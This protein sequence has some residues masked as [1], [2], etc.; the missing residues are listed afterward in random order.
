M[1]AG[2][3]QPAATSGLT[4]VTAGK[5]RYAPWVCKAIADG[6]SNPQLGGALNIVVHEA[7]HLFGERDESVAACWGL[8][9]AAD[10]ARRFYNVPF[11]SVASIKVMESARAVHASLSA[12]YHRVCL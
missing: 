9:W 2:A 12:D 10:L 3:G 6:P 7:V 5:A 1:V 4:W 8:V 11:F